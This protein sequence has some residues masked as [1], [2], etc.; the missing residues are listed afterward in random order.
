MT[1]SFAVGTVAANDSSK[2]LNGIGVALRISVFRLPP[3]RATIPI[4]LAFSYPY[5]SNIF[6]SSRCAPRPH[7]SSGKSVLQQY[8]HVGLRDTW[9]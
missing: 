7:I 2:S 6:G 1:W 5:F 4:R 8:N 9:P 3:T